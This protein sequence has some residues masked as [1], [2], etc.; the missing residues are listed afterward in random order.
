[1]RWTAFAGLSGVGRDTGSRLLEDTFGPYPFDAAGAIVASSGAEYSLE[2]QTRP[3]YPASELIE[4]G[5]P[6]LVHELAHQWV[7]DSLTLQSW[8]HIWLNEGFATYVSW[9][10]SEREGTQTAQ[11]TFD[12]V[13]SS[14]DADDPYW[15][16]LV[17]DPG[18]DHLF[19]P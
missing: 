13:Y 7:G 12:G 2:A 3:I 4:G 14:I 5:A 8:Q 17:G 1:L 11:Q 6:L 15:D 9:L 19:E 16:L 10:W 18:P